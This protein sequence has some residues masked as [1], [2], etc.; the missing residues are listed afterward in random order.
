MHNL[1]DV[2]RESLLLC[3]KLSIFGVK[4]SVCRHHA[5]ML[6]LSSRAAASRCF[7]SRPSIVASEGW[8]SAA[9]F[10]SVGL[11]LRGQRGGKRR[12]QSR[13]GLISSSTLFEKR[14]SEGLETSREIVSQLH[15]RRKKKRVLETA[16]IQVQTGIRGVDLSIVNRRRHCFFLRA[17]TWEF[18]AVTIYFGRETK[19]ET[20][21]TKFMHVVNCISSV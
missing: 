15:T 2:V 13:I 1:S 12:I 6:R 7:A 21:R 8:S 19:S 17:T 10:H 18:S 11:N 14:L 16:R 3:E 20:K 9:S 4:L 5:K